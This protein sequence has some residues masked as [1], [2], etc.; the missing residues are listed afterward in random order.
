M[1]E[2][3]RLTKS[4]S[5]KIAVN[6]LSCTIAPGEVLG[7]L[8]PNGAGKSTFM[9]MLAGFV[10]PTSGTLSLYGVD[11]IRHTR[12]AQRLI[13]YL[14][15]QSPCYSDMSARGFL[16][17]IAE[18]R[19]YRGAQKRQ[20]V[21]SMMERFGLE[22]MGHYPIED[23]SKGHRRRVA[24]AQTL[25][26]DPQVLILDEPTDGLDPN[27]KRHVREL[28]KGLAAERIVILSTHI[29]EEVEALC[30]RV[31][32]LDKGQILVD[33]SLEQLQARCRYHQAVTLFAA[34]PLD[35]LSLAVLPGVA[36]IEAG[37]QPNSVKVLA[38]AGE[39]IF[40]AINGLISR[41]G[42]D[43]RHQEVERGHLDEVF[44][45]LTREARA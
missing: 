1:I 43:V 42:W 33:S 5:K 26:H 22:D 2:L 27:Q 4:F 20:R 12:K 18:M 28:I 25:L 24:L 41:S 13:G 45:T 32:V 38:R 21:A 11:V 36:G 7:V 39:V 40:P 30:T 37:A 23:L 29:L 44:R 8:G 3:T 35:L 10:R 15:E 31:L 17:F 34:H 16:T 19:G 6:N 9:R 14:P